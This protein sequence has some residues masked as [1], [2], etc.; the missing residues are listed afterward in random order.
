M[1]LGNG[2]WAPASRWETIPP[3][4]EGDQG[5]GFSPGA[6]EQMVRILPSE[7]GCWKGPGSMAAVMSKGSPMVRRSCAG[8]SSAVA[9]N[10]LGSTRTPRPQSDPEIK[11]ASKGQ[12]QPLTPHSPA[13]IS[14]YLCTSQ[15]KAAQLRDGTKLHPSSSS[16]P[17]LLCLKC[18]SYHLLGNTWEKIL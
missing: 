12:A 15:E 5:P 3:E 13:K 8:Q 17:H 18:R 4:E 6:P 11:R 9:A 1:G 14:W 16:H 2:D 10:P 7:M